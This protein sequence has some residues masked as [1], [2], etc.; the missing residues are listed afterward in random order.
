MRVRDHIAL[1]TVAAALLRPSLDSG[2][3]G[4]WAGS[5]LIDA[6]HYAWFCVRHRRGSPLD[7]MRF[8]NEAHPPQHASTRVLHS[9]LALMVALLAGLRWPGLRTVACGMAAHVALDLGHNARMSRARAEVLA[10]D[11]SRC[12]ECGTRSDPLDVHVARQPWLL[13]SYSTE[14]LISLCGRCH[15]AAHAG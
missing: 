3:L 8:F 9:P 14:N 7:A 1:S 11:A 10:R 12:Q 13:P 2:V 4:L 6:D 5:V 15:E